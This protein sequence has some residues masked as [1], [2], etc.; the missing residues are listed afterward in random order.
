MSEP[1]NKDKIRDW[2]ARSP[3]TYGE[4]HGET[5]YRTEGGAIKNAQFGTRDLFESLDTVFYRWNANLHTTAGFFGKIFPYQR[6]KSKRVLEVGCGLGTMAMSWVQHGA[7]ITAVDLNPVSVAQTARRFT[8]YGLEGS[9]LQADANTLCF[10]DNLFDYAYSWGVLHHSPNLP[11][12]MDELFRVLKPGGGFGVML[13]N[14]VSVFYWYLTRYL[15]GYL[16]KESRFLD[17]LQLASRYTDGWEH[18]GNPHTWP[19]TR[20]E[21]QDVFSSY[22]DDVT[23]EVFGDISCGFPPKVGSYVPAFLKDA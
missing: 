23:I 1:A 18:E 2:W 19:V 7:R 5:I 16:H 8:L 15:E 13:Y 21:M 20:Q 3:M 9:I 12:S 4:V 6:Y 10:S 14:R 17:P 11:Q 22:S